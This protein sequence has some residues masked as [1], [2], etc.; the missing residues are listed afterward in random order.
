MLLLEMEAELEGEPL[1][2]VL[3][4]RKEDTLALPTSEL[5]TPILP[6]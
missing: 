5:V 1:A 6:E 2:L 4:V 3:R